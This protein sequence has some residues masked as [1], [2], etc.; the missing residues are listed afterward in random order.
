MMHQDG[1]NEH[2]G[3]LE[4]RRFDTF[5]ALLWKIG[6]GFLVENLPSPSLQFVEETDDGLMKCISR[7][8]CIELGPMEVSMSR[9]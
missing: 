6:W 8:Q 1:T 4:I 9:T 3:G 7:V 2:Q 5:L